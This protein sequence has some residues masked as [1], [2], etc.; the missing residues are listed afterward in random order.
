M[1]GATQLSERSVHR[2]GGGIP[3]VREYVRVDVEGEAD[4]R[5]AWKLLN[6]L[7][8]DALTQG[9]RGARAAEGKEAA[10]RRY[11]A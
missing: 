11:M 8:I 1:E 2:A 7:G 4:V 10:K 5:V 6:I 3:H 9:E